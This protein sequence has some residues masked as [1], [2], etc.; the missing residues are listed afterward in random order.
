MLLA[1][2]TRDWDGK[3]NPRCVTVWFKLVIFSAT[4]LVI[5]LLITSDLQQVG[6]DSIGFP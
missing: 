5:C 4:Q 1:Q 6:R 2:I 3:L